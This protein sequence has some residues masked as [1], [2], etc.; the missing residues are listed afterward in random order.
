MGNQSH[1]PS[2]L[3]A[4]A[5]SLLT[6][7]WTDASPEPKSSS[8]EMIQGR[9]MIVIDGEPDAF[10]YGGDGVLVMSALTGGPREIRLRNGSP[11]TLDLPKG[12]NTVLLD[13][14]TGAIFMNE[15]GPELDQLYINYEE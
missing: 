4:F 1:Y 6:S 3:F 13:S 14:N 12:P 5:M 2:I 9:P 7:H 15:Y 11:L 10:S 8:V